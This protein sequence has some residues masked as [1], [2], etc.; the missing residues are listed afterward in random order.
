MAVSV[1][2]ARHQWWL[3]PPWQFRPAW[4]RWPAWPTPGPARRATFFSW[5]R[6]FWGSQ[7]DAVVVAVVAVY[8]LGAKLLL[9]HLIC[10]EKWCTRVK[11]E[12]DPLFIRGI[13]YIW[14]F[15]STYIVWTSKKQIIFFYWLFC[16]PTFFRCWKLTVHNLSYFLT[17][18]IFF[19]KTVLFSHEVWEV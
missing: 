19:K 7:G 4:P 3:A 13:L 18:W 9:T 2:R 12:Y 14:L 15:F 10:I 16:L 5:R 17:Q 1:N 8:I 11:D 6:R